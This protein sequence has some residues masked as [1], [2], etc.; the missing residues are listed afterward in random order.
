MKYWK[1][2]QAGAAL[3]ETAIVISL[4]LL[5]VFGIIEFSLAIFDWS[6]AVEAT[7]AGVR[8]AIGNDPVCD[9]SG[10]SC[11]GG[12]PVV[13]ATPA[14]DAPIVTVM[15]R[16][17]SRIEP[18]NVTVTYACSTAGFRKRPEQMPIPAVTVGT[19][20][21]QHDLVI[22]GLLGLDASIDLPAFETTRTGEDL[23]TPG[24]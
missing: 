10:L 6:R 23:H 20:G 22:W 16:T 14:A 13:C 17:M 7:R 1:R 11:P 4:F 8:F 12:S 2:K 24:T 18:A 21:I 19:S 9:I 15:R 3:V 5:L